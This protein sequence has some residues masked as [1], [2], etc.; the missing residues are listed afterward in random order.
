MKTTKKD[1]I[2]VI[3]GIN[4]GIL[5]NTGLRMFLINRSTD[6]TYNKTVALLTTNSDSIK[7]TEYPD[8]YA[9]TERE[10]LSN[11]KTYKEVDIFLQGFK[12]CYNL[13]V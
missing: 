1:I 7:Y 8:Y 10:K 11:F 2:R 9:L 5:K 3:D 4:K 12:T 6:Y 13:E